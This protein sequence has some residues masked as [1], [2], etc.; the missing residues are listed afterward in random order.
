MISQ[1]S[2]RKS[3]LG[4]VLICLGGCTNTA[5][6]GKF[7]TSTAFKASATSRPLQGVG[8]WNFRNGSEALA[9]ANASWFYTWGPDTRGIT[10]PPGVEFVPMI[11]APQN[12]V[13]LDKARSLGTTLLGFNEPDSYKQADMSPQQALDLWPQLMATNMRLGSPATADDAQ[14]RGSWFDQFMKGAKAH[15]YRVDFI[16]LHKYEKNFADPMAAVEDLRDY[17][18]AVH[19]KYPDKPIWLTEFALTNYRGPG[20]KFPTVDQQAAFASAAVRMLH[21]LPYVERYAWFALSPPKDPTDTRPLADPNGNLTKV[22]LA[23]ESAA[24]ASR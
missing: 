24:F 5:T 16:C 13:E 3:M 6:V 21:T 23:Y 2:L 15:S 9:K 17:L 10:P 22:G 1:Q 7:P 8:A 12:M 20:A 18:E 19:E 11:R 14:K 4:L